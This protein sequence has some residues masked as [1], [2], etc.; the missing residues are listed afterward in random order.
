MT[1]FMDAWKVAEKDFSRDGSA[2]EKLAFCVRYAALA[3]STYN[4][5]PWYFVVDKD[6]VS[7]YADRRY[8]LA[9]IDPDDR[10]LVMA[11]GAALFT[12]R[13]AISHFGYEETTELL[14]DSKD[15]DLLARVKIG[16]EKAEG[17]VQNPIFSAITKRHMNHGAFAD[18]AVPEEA[19][20]RLINAAAQ[21]GAWLHI[22]NPVEREI[23]LQMVLE[24]D[25]ILCGDKHFRRELAAWTDARRAL[26]GDGYPHMGGK[27]A[28]VVSSL[29]P[30]LLRRFESDAHRVAG[31]DELESGTPVLAVLGR[32]AGGVLERLNAGQALMRVLLQAEADGLSVS[33]LNQP[34]EVPE[35]RLRLHDELENPGRAQVVMRIG[36][37]GKP[38][39]TPRRALDSILEVRGGRKS[40]NGEGRASAPAGSG[41]L[42]RM[43]NLFKS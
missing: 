17:G 37:G 14:P 19:R 8:A 40:A 38:T 10:E 34:V 5:Q 29:Q 11:C 27:F 42:S 23:I 7:L 39:H 32:K 12:L 30:H 1:D 24:G 41:V 3:P 18:K 31:G 25:H 15:S 33:T 28:D 6:V 22:C 26:N 36:F 9:V 16:A 35:L 13:L 21:E 4:T 20:T 43:K 2:A